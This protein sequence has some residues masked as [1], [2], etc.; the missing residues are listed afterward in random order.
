MM[1]LHSK[2]ICFAD[3]PL[4][5]ILGVFTIVI[6]ETP[7][8]RRDYQTVKPPASETHR[9]LV[10]VHNERPCAGPIRR[11]SLTRP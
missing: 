8:Y 11:H 3:E 5:T 1:P 4:H 7:S 10:E 2:Y 9:D 6:K